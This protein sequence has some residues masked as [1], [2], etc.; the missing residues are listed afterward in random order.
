MWMLK[1]SRQSRHTTLHRAFQQTGINNQVDRLGKVLEILT[2]HSYSGCE[3]N[4]LIESQ[5]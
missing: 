4:V 3:P 2:N 1:V 5:P